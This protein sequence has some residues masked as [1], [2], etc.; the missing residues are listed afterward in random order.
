MMQ[1]YSDIKM[2]TILIVWYDRIFLSSMMQVGPR[3]EKDLAK[4]L[5]LV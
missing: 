1:V 3:T 4:N 5:L 2:S